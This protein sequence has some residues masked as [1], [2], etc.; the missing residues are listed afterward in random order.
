MILGID[1]GTTNSLAGLVEDGKVA[2]VTFEGTALLPS[3]VSF[4]DSGDMLIG[5]PARNQYFLE[6]ENSVKSIKRLM[7]SDTKTHLNGQ[8][9]LPEEISAMI[10]R[11]I[12]ATAERQ[13]GADIREAVI[14][15]PAYFSDDQRQATAK[16]GQ[17]AG[18][19]VKRIIN[20]P[21]AA[22]LAYNFDHEGEIK[23]VVYDL[24]GGTFDVS[25]VNIQQGIVEVMA[26]HGNNQLGGDDFDQ[27][28]ADH[29]ADR[30]K[31]RY[32]L[33]LRDLPRAQRRLLQIAEKC[34][35][36]LSD[37]AFYQIVENIELG[38]DSPPLNIELEISRLDFETMIESLIDETMNMVH[39]ALKDA[40][41]NT[42]RIDQILLV[43]G[44]S[45]IPLIT[46]KFENIFPIAPSGSI[47]MDQSV[48]IGAAL[49]AAI[50]NHQKIDA[51]LIDVTPYTFGTRAVRQN[52]MGYI[53]DDDVF[54]PVIKR[55]T[56]LPVSKSEVFYKV[57]PAQEK[58]EVKIYQGE[59]KFASH[60]KCIGFFTIQD[61]SDA[62]NSEEIILTMSLDLNG[63]LTVVATEKLTGKQ[64]RVT[65]ENAFQSGDIDASIDRIS[66]LFGDEDPHPDNSIEITAAE[67]EDTS[68]DERSEQKWFIARTM[69]EKA[70]AKMDRAEPEDAREMQA[71]IEQLKPEIDR[72]NTAVVERLTD[73]LTDIL[74]Y[75]D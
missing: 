1:L 18:F 64:K 66:R 12:K 13:F 11:H 75:I 43:G 33:D 39:L 49:Q 23:A 65:I 15:V 68:A 58:I 16:A 19:E 47:D 45:R 74:F 31:E 56:P 6:P 42:D 73:Q 24:G 59:R 72:Q 40:G 37:H 32:D 14:T 9:Y 67:S 62:D 53:E 55:N 70:E 29:I 3:V 2:L 7:G 17:I 4:T 54:V 8:H 21:T 10:L 26:S 60:N 22:S 71:I 36:T 25:I 44:S 35:C 28:L 63:I 27:M 51:I 5:R 38:A 46:R 41:L 34:K 30:V 57:H 52:A 50:I 61:L 20:E 69:I 48:C